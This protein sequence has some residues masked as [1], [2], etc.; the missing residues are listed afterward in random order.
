MLLPIGLQHTGIP[1]L[2]VETQET[3]ATI[4]TLG[5]ACN[6]RN[7]N[8]I[9]N[10]WNSTTPITVLATART[11]INSRTKVT[12]GKPATTGSTSAAAGRLQQQR[13]HQQK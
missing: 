9:R 6:S 12:A 11:Q 8:N 10:T 3:E 5:F 13:G 1:Q 4:T 2:T 7:D